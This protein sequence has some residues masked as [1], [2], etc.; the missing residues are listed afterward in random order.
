LDIRRRTAENRIIT[1][2]KSRIGRGRGFVYLGM[3]ESESE[4]RKRA[5]S[6]GSALIGGHIAVKNYFVLGYG[7]KS[8]S[9]EVGSCYEPMAHYRYHYCPS[10]LDYT[11]YALLRVLFMSNAN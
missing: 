11:K 1:N 9:I 6:L 4:K 7:R 3:K 10:L 8:H 5:E 2:K